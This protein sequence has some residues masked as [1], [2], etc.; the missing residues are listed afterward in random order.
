M[1]SITDWPTR[2]E[3]DLTKIVFA[4]RNDSD[5]FAGRGGGAGVALGSATAVAL[6][7]GIGGAGV[8]IFAADSGPD[9]PR[10]ERGVV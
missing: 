7:A 8:A 6:G 4:F 1:L 5:A 10:V 9:L 2:S 3:C